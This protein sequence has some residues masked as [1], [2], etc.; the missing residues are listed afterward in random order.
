MRVE[1]LNADSDLV[2]VVVRWHWHEWSDAYDN[3]NF[4][5]WRARVRQ[6]TNHDRVP[7]TFVAHFDGEPVGSLSVCDDDLD[8]Q[9]AD[10]GPWLSGMLVV[11][12]ARNM[13][14]GRALLRVTEDHARS[15]DVAELWCSTAEAGAFYERCGWTCVRPKVRLRDHGVLRR[16]L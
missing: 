7:F 11:G 8:E 12:W 16:D 2:D 3:P 9:F 15:L 13:G 4:D 14:V 5:E 6:R 1:L 10:R